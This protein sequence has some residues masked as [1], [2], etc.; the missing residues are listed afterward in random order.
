MN[1]QDAVNHLKSLAQYEIDHSFLMQQAVHNLKDSEIIQK[2]GS[3]RDAI[4]DNI[5]QLC[6]AVEKLGG[7][8]PEHSRDFKGF[9]MQGY[10]A[11]RGI[12]SDYGV[13]QAL[14]SNEKLIMDAYEKTLHL[15]LPQEAQKVVQEAYNKDKGIL[16]TVHGQAEML[17]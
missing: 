8:A 6:A 5:K 4:E 9:F 16:Q 14:D 2:L 12:T 1:N 7:E 13:L 10:A 11:L 3:H 15:E 17:K